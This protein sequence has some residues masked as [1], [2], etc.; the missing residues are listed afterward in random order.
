MNTT[1]TLSLPP[2][3][4]LLLEQ[5]AAMQQQL[6]NFQV[7]GAWLTEKEAAQRLKVNECEIRTW[8]LM[9]WLRHYEL[10]GQVR[11]K[12]DELDQDF[13][14]QAQV[15]LSFEKGPKEGNSYLDQA[16]SAGDDFYQKTVLRR[17]N[18]T[19]LSAA[20]AKANS[21]KQAQ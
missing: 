3:Q 5:I 18:V 9:G 8:R 4:L 16:K 15:N 14:T 20:Q 7:G 6:I 11:Y 10:D 13:Q 19:G 12:S 21:R 2:E 1:I 17:R